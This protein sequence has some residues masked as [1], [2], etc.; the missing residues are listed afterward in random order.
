MGNQG[1]VEN[2]LKEGGGVSFIRNPEGLRDLFDSQKGSDGLRGMLG[3]KRK[4]GANV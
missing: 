3:M 2:L 4:G 1:R